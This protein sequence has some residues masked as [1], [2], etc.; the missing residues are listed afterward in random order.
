MRAST[1]V[2]TI[3]FALHAITGCQSIEKVPITREMKPPSSW[4]DQHRQI[5][6]KSYLYA[7]MASNTYGQAGDEYGSNGLEFVLPEAYTSEHFPNNEI[8]FAYS[9]YRKTESGKLIELIISFRGT[10]GLTNIDDF[11]HGN[12]LARQNSLAIAK[13]KELRSQLNTTGQADVP[14]TLTGHSLGGA[15]AIHTAINVAEEVPYYVFNAS[16][17]INLIEQWE[18]DRDPKKLTRHSVVETGEFLYTLRFPAIEANQTYTP[19]NCNDHFRPFSSHGIEK[20]A[21]CLTM[22]AAMNDPNA[23]VEMRLKNW[24]IY[25]N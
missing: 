17:R 3:T 4:P 9:I 14:I 10:E 5:A 23:K 15:L 7:Q 20:L 1:L 12:L 21:T 11:V 16:P 13:Y 19:M 24:A 22:V 8:G 25:N 2:I 18:N 6:L